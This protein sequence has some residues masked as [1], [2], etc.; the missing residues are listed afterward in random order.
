MTAVPAEPGWPA[1]AGIR[2]G[3]LSRTTKSHLAQ[4]AAAILGLLV[5]RA[6]VTGA[7]ARASGFLDR[8]VTVGSETYRFQVY[9]PAG[10]AARPL[11]IILWLHG[12]G[13]QGVDGSLP[14][15]GAMGQRIR[16]GRE[17]FPAIVVFPQARPDHLWDDSM[18][19]V[20]LAALEAATREFRADRARTYLMGFSMGG[21][22]AWWLASRHP[23]RFAAAVVIAGPVADI[24]VRLW[25]TGQVETAMRE[26]AYLRSRDPFGTLAASLREL[27]VWLFIGSDDPLAPPGDGRRMG[28]ALRK[29]NPA[30]RFTEYEGVGH[31][32]RRALAEKELWTWLLARQRSPGRP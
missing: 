32:A 24:P 18:Q 14:T 26:N 4:A 17:P 23:E 13:A 28:E 3:V 31:D 30:A 21:R 22:G 16:T 1:E 27:P 5:A 9:V 29:V 25:S 2:G 19:T 8:S 6:P 11:P 12:N 7:Q 10:H 20:A 15:R